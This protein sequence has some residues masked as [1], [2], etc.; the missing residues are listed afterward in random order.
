VAADV[1]ASLGN[2]VHQA[3]VPEF[4]NGSPDRAAGDLVLLLHGG[5]GW[6]GLIGR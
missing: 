1:G 4:F 5:F 3:S 2:R 6:D